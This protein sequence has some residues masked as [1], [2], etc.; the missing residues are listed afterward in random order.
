MV[1]KKIAAT[2]TLLAL[3][4]MQSNATDTYRVLKLESSIL[5]TVDGHVIGIDG[6][7]LAL[8]KQYDAGLLNLLIGKRDQT[9]QRIGMYEFEGAQRTVQELTKI[10]AERGQNEELFRLCQQ[11]RKDFEKM[12]EIFR[13]VARGAK[14]FMGILIGES[15]ERRGRLHSILY[16]WAKTDVSRED[17]LF[18]E[19][20]KE[21]KDMD[22]FLT[23]LHNFLG[24]LVHSCPKALRQFHEKIAKFNKIKN[25]VPSLGI[26]KDLQILF[27][28]QINKALS[29]LSLEQITLESVRK[30]FNEFKN[31]Q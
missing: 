4:S 17:D 26:A 1:I 21:I 16:I 7:T 3:L 27:L 22:I 11:I 24:D 9:G 5:A 12:S 28:K 15:C 8:I 29:T 14:P 25:I 23:D 10:E 2:L 30:L 20:I 18:D 19:Y 31:K 13:A 6:D